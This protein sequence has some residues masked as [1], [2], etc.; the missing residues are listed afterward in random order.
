MRTS[1]SGNVH[2]GGVS[3]SAH[4]WLVIYPEQ[5]LVVALNANARLDEFGDF[6]AIEQ[7]IT[8]AFLNP[9]GGGR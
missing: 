9:S 5:R 7:A 1:L 6:I 8:R 2:H 4:S 3:K